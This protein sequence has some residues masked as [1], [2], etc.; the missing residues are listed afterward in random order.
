VRR[1]LVTGA[2]GLLGA[3]IIREFA[4]DADLI[5]LER[6][7]LD[8]TDAA[9]VHRVLGAARPD[10][11]I[12][13]VA[14]N[15]VDAAEDDPGTALS[16]NAL[17]VLA[18]S[19]AAQE[20]GAVFVHYSSDFVFDGETTRPYAEDDSPNPRGA[21]AASKL[22][23]DWLAL[24]HPAAYVL[25]VES[26]FG[27]P[28]P[29]GARA[30]SVGT[31]V[32]RIRAGE[33][34]PVFVDRTVSPSYTTDIASATREL[35]ERRSAAGLYHVVNSGVATWADIAA[36]AARLLDRPLH[37]RP[38]TLDTV[39]LKAP[40]PKYCALSNAKLQA[41]GIVMPAW[42]D[43]IRRYLLGLDSQLPGPSVPG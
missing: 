20:A 3:A 29:G 28:G 38:I 16:V 31:I 26:L 33:P 15:N 13:C 2:R 19:R 9:A 12:N 27:A 10:I 14:F 40:R 22:L 39:A 7:A 37:I 24:E 42:Q 41:A 32:Q 25:R 30:G 34:V 18:L 17:G 1:V 21:Y 11:V 43:A 4:S 36:E 6:A 23:G 35:L 5:A 8:I